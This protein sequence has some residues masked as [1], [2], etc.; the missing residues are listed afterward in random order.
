[1]AL[2]T[3]T[4]GG[5]VGNHPTFI[6]LDRTL[7]P[8]SVAYHI[9]HTGFP[10][11]FRR[12]DV[13]DHD[14]AHDMAY[15]MPLTLGKHDKEDYLKEKARGYLTIARMVEMFYAGANFDIINPVEHIEN[16]RMLLHEHLASWSNANSFVGIKPDLEGLTAMRDFYSV[17]EVI[18][19][20]AKGKLVNISRSEFAETLDNLNNFNTLLKPGMNFTDVFGSIDHKPATPEA[21]AAI[22]AVAS[23]NNI[24]LD[25][26]YDN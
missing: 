3:A 12:I 25:A 24:F 22:A 19:K 18:G 16:I 14:A 17:V 5:W 2:T 15:T 13:M 11:G 23:G 21:E 1:M 7:F 6:M 20:D 4:N 10:A 26:L 8:Y 9:F